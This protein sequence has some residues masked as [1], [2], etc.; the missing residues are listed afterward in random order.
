[1][2]YAPERLS[3]TWFAIDKLYSTDYDGDEVKKND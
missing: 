2:A 3:T 1:M